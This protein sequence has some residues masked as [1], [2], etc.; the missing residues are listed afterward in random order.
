M[1]ERTKTSYPRLRLSAWIVVVLLVLIGHLSW[2][3]QLR[4]PNILNNDRLLLAGPIGLT[5][6]LL[7]MVWLLSTTPANAIRLRTRTSMIV[8]L[9]GAALLNLAALLWIVPALSEDLIR[10]RVDGATWLAG[11]SPYATAPAELPHPDRIDRAVTYPAVH[12]IYPPVSQLL[13]ANVR[14][15]ETLVSDWP[16]DGPPVDWRGQFREASPVY[17]AI[18]YRATSA[19]LSLITAAVLMAILHRAGRSVWWAAIFSWHP[20]TVMEIAGQ[21]HHDILGILLIALTVFLLQ[22][23]RLLLAVTALALASGVKPFALLLLPFLCRDIR[24][25][26]GMPFTHL[27]I[28]LF[29]IV[30]AVVYLP[31]WAQPEALAGWLKTGQNYSNAW[32]ANGSVYEWIKGPFQGGDGHAMEN[33]KQMARVVALAGLLLAMLLAWQARATVTEAGYWLF[34]VLLLTSPVVYPWYLLWVLAMIPL[35]RPPQGL[36]GLVWAGTVVVCHALWHQPDW[37]LP[38]RLVLA[39]YLPVFAALLMEW[40]LLLQR[41]WPVQI[42]QISIVSARI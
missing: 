36:A 1:N 10:Y 33:A 42:P 28:G 23:Q 32:E 12:T 30:I 31:I 41:A 5:P 2:L 16:G 18:L 27:A 19:A 6:A 4:G 25:L 40:A 8:I 14:L 17:R 39:E 35:A 11:R 37:V 7:A 38:P 29:V 13:F 22:R 20:L 34:L 21:G 3:Y 9:A 26:R 24:G 15:I